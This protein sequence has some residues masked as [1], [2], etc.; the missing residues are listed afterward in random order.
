M[1]GGLGRRYMTELTP[2]HPARLGPWD[3]G[4]P[5]PA[6]HS[7]GGNTACPLTCRRVPG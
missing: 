6:P 5:H 4:T 1:T 3:R 7:L 2:Q